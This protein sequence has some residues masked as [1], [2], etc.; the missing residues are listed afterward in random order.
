MANAL[1]TQFSV[2]IV[3]PYFVIVV[4]CRRDKGNAEERLEC[5]G[6]TLVGVCSSMTNLEAFSNVA[7]IEVDWP[8]KNCLDFDWLVLRVS[9]GE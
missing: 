8:C 2:T 9:M 3:I 1:F 6:D 5:S 4:E 7:Y